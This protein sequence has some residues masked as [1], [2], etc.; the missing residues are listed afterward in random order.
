[1]RQL[2]FRFLMIFFSNEFCNPVKA[3]DFFFNPGFLIKLEIRKIVKPPFQVTKFIGKNQV[4]YDVNGEKQQVVLKNFGF[5][6]QS[7]EII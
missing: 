5:T 4:G 7:I 6:N 1:M 2:S 3:N